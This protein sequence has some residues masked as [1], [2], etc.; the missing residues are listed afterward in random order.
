VHTS[1][2][3]LRRLP[4]AAL[5]AVFSLVLAGCGGES[6]TPKLSV[7]T[8]PQ[9]A[10]IPGLH[11]GPPHVIAF[12][13]PLGATNVDPARTTLAVTFDRVMDREG[14]AWVIEDKATAPEIGESSWDAEVRTNSAPVRL[15]PGKTYVVWINSP[16]YSYFKDT[17]GETATP[18]R[19]TFTT[20]A[21][22]APAAGS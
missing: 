20:R 18:V 19:W 2:T 4:G 13:P 5:L 10:N 3:R 11:T 7:T 12:D 1:K 21:A 14:W 15:E 17:L 6:S 16:Q 8:T 22:T 9:A